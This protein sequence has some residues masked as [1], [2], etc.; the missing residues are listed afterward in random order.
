MSQS[1]N[2]CITLRCCS[3]LLLN[4]SY[5]AWDSGMLAVC[6]MLQPSSTYSVQQRGMPSGADYWHARTHYDWRRMHKHG[7]LE[8]RYRCLL[9]VASAAYLVA[10]RPRKDEERP[11][12]QRRLRG[13]TSGG[14]AG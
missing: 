4:D 11:A 13:P 9:S 6:P 8:E 5:C 7:P 10:Y 3:S 1:P 12:R 2:E 14:P